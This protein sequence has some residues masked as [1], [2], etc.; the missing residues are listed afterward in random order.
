MKM[1]DPADD[2]K[3]KSMK[4]I[5]IH[6][7]F[8]SD[9]TETTFWVKELKIN[10]DAAYI[11]KNEDHTQTIS[12]GKITNIVSQYGDC[13]GDDS[14]Y[15]AAYEKLL[16]N[17]SATSEFITDNDNYYVVIETSGE[18]TVDEVVYED[19]YVC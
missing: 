11:T 4:T 10:A 16:G 15:N 1:Y 17:G 3:G 6:G 5:T 2:Q 7:G 13:N 18:E 8:C 12:K 19:T 9:Y 14:E